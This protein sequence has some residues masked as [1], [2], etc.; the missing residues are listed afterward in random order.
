MDK[1]NMES[2]TDN[3]NM[4][5]QNYQEVHGPLHDHMINQ[6]L[7]TNAD[8]SLMLMPTLLEQSPFFT[9]TAIGSGPRFTMRSHFVKNLRSSFTQVLH[10]ISIVLPFKRLIITTSSP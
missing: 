5:I 8:V 3:N 1:L 6:S 9:S 2:V 7:Y 4:G 10:I